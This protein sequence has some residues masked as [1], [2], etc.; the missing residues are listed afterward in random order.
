MGAA[1][2]GMKGGVRRNGSGRVDRGPWRVGMLLQGCAGAVGG[3]L[4]CVRGGR[5]R[6]GWHGDMGT[7][8]G[9]TLGGLWAVGCGWGRSS[10]WANGT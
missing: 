1:E 5:G 9:A 3:S 2:D 7:G 4:V 6:I 8:H 10:V